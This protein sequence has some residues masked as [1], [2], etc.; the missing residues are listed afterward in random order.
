MSTADTWAAVADRDTGAK[1]WV[2]TQILKVARLLAE[3]FG[4][5]TVTTCVLPC[6]LPSSFA[7]CATTVR[8]PTRLPLSAVT[9]TVSW[10]TFT[11]LT[12]GSAICTVAVFD[13]AC[14]LGATVRGDPAPDASVAMPTATSTAIDTI[15]RARIG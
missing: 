14:A 5:T 8:L 13:A 7:F 10:L 9:L 2:K 12:G 4:E 3:D 6:G 1:R 15:D 11:L